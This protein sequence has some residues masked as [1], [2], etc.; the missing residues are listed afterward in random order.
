MR[1]L[2]V[3]PLLG[4][5][6]AERQISILVPA[7]IGRGLDVRVVTLNG[8]GRFFDDLRREGVPISC[9]SMAR[10]T[11][12][13]GIRRLFAAASFGPDVLVTRSVNAQVLGQALATRL[14]VP[15]VTME[16]TGPD[17]A[18][19]LRPMRRHQLALLRLVA[20]R[21]ARV[22]ATSDT[23][24]PGLVEYG[25]RADRISVIENTVPDRLE[26]ERP[27]S[28]VRDELGFGD[29]Q[30]VVVL[31]AALRPEKRVDAFVRAVVKAR[32]LDSSIRGVVVGDGPEFE[33]VERAVEESGE[34]VRL[35]GARNDVPDLIE[36]AD[37]VCLSSAY[38]A[39]PLVVLE[40]M[41]VGRPVVAPDVGGLGSLVQAG[42]TGLLYEA[43][44]D[45][46]LASAL[47]ELAR[48]RDRARRMGE[49]AQLRKRTHFPLDGLVDGY[50]RVLR[51]AVNGRAELTAGP[52]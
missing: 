8:E 13:R 25:Y 2:F 17:A 42:E 41:A 16:Q 32:Q 33:V 15:H 4:I 40:A 18:G 27:R 14:R 36:A 29:D 10:R 44:D 31:A 46:A 48:D 49:A 26:L 7:L 12:V 11:D 30:F 5:G 24:I 50:L 34:A 52:A 35:L 28:A 47:T 1:V 51:E 3:L 23:Q 37:A 19:R 21:V 43:L 38:E 9:V 45:D 39:V 6:G 22:V 20:P